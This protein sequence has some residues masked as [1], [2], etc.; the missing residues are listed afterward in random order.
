MQRPAD[1]LKVEDLSVT[2]RSDAGCVRAVRGISF[3]IARGE[4]LA[5]VG[6]SGC[7]KS[8]SSLALMRLLPRSAQISAKMLRFQGI[9][10]LSANSRAYG[11]LR[12]DRIAMIFQEPMTNL[13]PILT[14]GEQLAEPIMR[15]RG[16]PRREALGKAAHLLD[17]VGIA[18]ATARLR[19]YPH[20]FSGGMRQ[21]VVIAMALVCGPDLLL[22]DEPTTALDVTTQVQ[23][24][25]LLRELI[26]EFDM[27]LLIITHDLGVVARIASRTAVMYAGEIVEAGETE[28][29]LVDPHHPYTRGLLASVPGRQAP[30]T[31]LGTIPGVVPSLL[32]AP[33][34]CAFRDRC[35]LVVEACSHPVKMSARGMHEYRCVH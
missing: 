4:T 14:I 9:D 8:A 13:N 25:D 19:Q 12:G 10:L 28:K 16:T 22:A 33:V 27:G 21:R 20:E 1:L 24:L 15:H 34:G 30:G 18:D 17:R 32:Q 6:E 7:G 23:I 35:S 5:L 31:P 2:F 11:D 3:E 26:A 29:V